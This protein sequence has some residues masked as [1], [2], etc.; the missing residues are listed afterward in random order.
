MIGYV[1]SVLLLGFYLLIFSTLYK[2]SSRLK[3]IPVVL[4]CLLGFCGGTLAIFFSALTD[5]PFYILGFEQLSSR[6]RAPI[7][8]ETIKAAVIV[9]F[10]ART[11]L[12]SKVRTGESSIV[13]FGLVLGLSFAFVENLFYVGLY[14]ISLNDVVIRGFFTWVMHMM[15][16]FLSAYGVR[17]SLMS[18][19]IFW[20]LPYLMV[21][22]LVH[23][24]VNNGDIILHRFGLYNMN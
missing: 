21:A 19:K 14:K 6:I 15:G 7:L 20:C 5:V 22:I 13:Y 16:A 11:K 10:F 9:V 17:K 12:S 1:V 3:I 2:L 8:E 4:L 24:M 18:R 23:F